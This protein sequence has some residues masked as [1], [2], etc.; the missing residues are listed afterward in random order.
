VVLALVILLTKEF[1][2][3]NTDN[4]DSMGFNEIT[5]KV[6]QKGISLN[7]RLYVDNNKM[8]SLDNIYGIIDRYNGTDVSIRIDNNCQDSHGRYKIF[9]EDGILYNTWEDNPLVKL[10]YTKEEICMI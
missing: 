2:F 7:Q 5:F 3:L 1:D 9:R 6:L 10:F 8:E 4:F